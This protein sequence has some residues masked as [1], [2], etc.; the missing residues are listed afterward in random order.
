MPR[1]PK[2]PHH[3]WRDPALPFAESRRAQH[4]RACY[5]PHSH[6][7]LSIG[8]VDS[9]RSVLELPG[10]A[11]QA[12][13]AGDVVVIPADCVHACNP[14]PNEAWS[15]QMLYLDPDWLRTLFAEACC[16]TPGEL[17]LTHRFWQ[18]NRALY[19]AFCTLN[20][21]LFSPAPS[22]H[23]EALLIDFAGLAVHGLAPAAESQDPAW[24][25]AVKQLL[26]T[27]SSAAWPLDE[28][29]AEVGVSRYHLVRR[30]KAWCGLTP[31]A[32]LL[33]CRI[34]EAR[35]LLA[36]DMPLAQLALEL[37]FADQSHFVHAFRQRVSVTPGDYRRLIRRN[38]LQ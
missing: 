31:H 4:S 7:T 5:R 37:G 32:Y 33:D 1:P 21:Q 28:L 11:P 13:A 38:F 22:A 19:H 27:R 24:L 3:F 23:K 10:R 29:A 8:A 34:N 2:P 14:E 35:R 16:D 15:Y 17:L 30:F 25:S 9:G 36:G 20:A 18:R 12:L 26:R 6:P